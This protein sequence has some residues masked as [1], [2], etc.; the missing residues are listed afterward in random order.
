MNRFELIMVAGE[1]TRSKT[2]IA[3]FSS[4][5]VANAAKDAL[6]AGM[7]ANSLYSDVS[8]EIIPVT[9]A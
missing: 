4:S 7:R 2:V 5:E 1:M 6:Y 8:Y 9:Y 3:S